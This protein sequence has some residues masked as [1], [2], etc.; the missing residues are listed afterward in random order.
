MIQ[1]DK[2]DFLYKTLQK[3]G[4]NQEDIDEKYLYFAGLGI[5]NAKDFN[6]HIQASLGLDFM[7]EFN[8]EWF[9]DVAEYYKDLRLAKLPCKTKTTQMLKQYK[10]N[11]S[12][13]LK[14]DIIN[15]QLKEVLLIA[16]AYKISHTDINL[17]DLVQISN[18]GLITAVDKFDVNAKLS[19][20]TYLNYWIMEAINNEFTKGEK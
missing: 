4:V 16:C 6:N 8:E 1:I 18:L 2:T 14:M 15:S 7:G 9:D 20:D 17:S 3:L 19:F 13:K 10:Q 5:S 12:E 11:P